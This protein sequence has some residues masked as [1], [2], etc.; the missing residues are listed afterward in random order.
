MSKECPQIGD[1][2]IAALD[3]KDIYR[4][5]LNTCRVCRQKFTKNGCTCAGGLNPINKTTARC[6]IG[7]KIVKGGQHKDSQGYTPVQ[8]V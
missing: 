3:Q 4:K 8:E 1:N 5:H 6:F 2:E 7:C